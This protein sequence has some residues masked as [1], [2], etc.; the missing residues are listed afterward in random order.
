MWKWLKQKLNGLFVRKV[1]I[2]EVISHP[3]FGATTMAKPRLTP[4]DEN[5]IETVGKMLK[6][7][8][9]CPTCGKDGF[10]GTFHKEF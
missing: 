5:L 2:E 9:S 3:N 8:R 6:N 4:Q 10:D 1:S 7:G